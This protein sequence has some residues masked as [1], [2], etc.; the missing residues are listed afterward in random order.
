MDF[1]YQSKPGKVVFGKD[2][3]KTIKAEIREWKAGRVLIVS[4]PGRAT[5][6]KE[7]AERLEGLC[8]GIHDKAVQHVP[9]ET[10]GELVE[11]IRKENVDGLVAIGGG[12]PIGLAKAAALEV[13]LPILAIP[14]TYSGSEMTSVWGITKEGEK[15]TGKNDVVKPRTVIYDPVLTV[16]MPPLLTLTSGVNAMAH[17]VEALYAENKNP[18]TSLIAEEG[19][20]AL[21]NSLSKAVQD[22]DDLESRSEVFYG[23]WLAGTTLGTVSLALHHKLCHVLGGSCSLPH[24]ETHTVILSYAIAYNSDNIPEALDAMAR[25]FETKPDRVAGKIFDMVYALGGPVSLSEIG[26]NQSDIEKAADLVT[27]NAYYNP[28][29]IHKKDIEHLLEQAFKGERPVQQPINA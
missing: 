16:S 27:R 17:C 18:I 25:A 28:R 29:P 23:A 11:R 1:S 26:M 9:E 13:S 4:T 22:P 2:R 5:V 6:S 20:R 24:S 14:T 12:S 15:Q 10:V 21:Y 7:A 19:I 8:V 3:R